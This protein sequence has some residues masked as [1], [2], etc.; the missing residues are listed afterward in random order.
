MR[1]F[2]PLILI[3]IVL[4]CAQNTDQT[5]IAV[6]VPGV[7]E[8]N[9]TYEMMDLGVRRA[10]EGSDVE[11]VTIE[12]GYDQATWSDQL[13]SLASERRHALIVTS[14]PAMTE[15]AVNA[16]KLIKGQEFLVLDGSEVEQDEIANV[17]YDHMEQAFL[18]GY[19][20]ALQLPENIQNPRIGMI[21]GQE[22]PQMNQAIRPGFE[23]GM[24]TVNPEITLDFRVLGNWND[25]EK[26]RE[27][28][29]GLYNQGVPSILTIAGNANYGVIAAAKESNK[30]V[31]WFDSDGTSLAPG[32]VLASAIVRQDLAAEEYTRLWLNKELPMGLHHTLGVKEGYVDFPLEGKNITSYIPAKDLAEMRLL[33]DDLTS[34]KWDFHSLND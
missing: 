19:F 23:M 25:A 28:A 26:A 27:M 10:A 12:G 21:V 2:L 13:V 32:T 5:K 18:I 7:L 17:S 8:G 3:F 22:Y 16:A 15:I 30:S 29:S 31:L 1:R 6:F 33:L 34:G 4:S 11:V 9:P 24:H 14:N 20:A